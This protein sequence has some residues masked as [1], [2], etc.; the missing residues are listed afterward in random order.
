MNFGMWSATLLDHTFYCNFMKDTQPFPSFITDHIRSF[1]IPWFFLF[2][3][4]Y[5]TFKWFSF[6]AGSFA[7]IHSFSSCSRRMCLV[8]STDTKLDTSHSSITCFAVFLA[9]IFLFWS[10]SVPLCAA[11][12]VGNHILLDPKPFLCFYT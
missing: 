5:L 12:S 10:V 9:D 7:V 1:R 2:D 6:N 8:V 11:A 3:Q 4:L